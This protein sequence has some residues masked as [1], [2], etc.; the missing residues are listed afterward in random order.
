MEHA[1][2]SYRV[3][4]RGRYVKGLGRSGFFLNMEIYKKIFRERLGTEPYPG[5]LN[6]EAEDLEGYEGLRKI[7]PEHEAIG[8]ITLEGKTYGGLYLWRALI[9]DTRVLL[10]RPYRSSHNPKI[11]EV[12]S[13]EKLVEK[14]GI[15][16]GD[17]I[18]IDIECYEKP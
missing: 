11:L 4:L 7:C 13:S 2:P 3:R 14:H 1:G 16:E 9:G 10:I 17:R 8:D 6:I 15:R 12:V 5:T 18:T